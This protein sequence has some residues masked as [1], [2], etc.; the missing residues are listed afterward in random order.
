MQRDNLWLTSF[1]TR[2]GFDVKVRYLH[3]GDT[4]HLL[5]VF[6]HMGEESRYQR[7][8]QS[9]EGMSTKRIWDEASQIAETTLADNRGLIAFAD[10]PDQ[11]HAP[12][13]V[14][15]YVHISPEKAEVAMSVRDDMQGQ[16]VGTTL[17]NLLLEEAKSAG[18]QTLVGMLQNSNS[19]MWVVF[20]RIPYVVRRMPDGVVSDV[21]IDLTKLKMMS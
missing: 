8:N 17:L 20:D 18:L 15:R 12:I 2:N 14:A 10:L 1:L 3:S 19:G 5:D 13:A 6:N 4:P 7:F 9:I 21:E 16:G 11:A